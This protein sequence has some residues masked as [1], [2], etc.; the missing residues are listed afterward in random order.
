MTCSKTLDFS[1]R[2]VHPSCTRIKPNLVIKITYACF[3]PP[4][5]SELSL[6]IH[7]HSAYTNGCIK[8]GC[9]LRHVT[10][11]FLIQ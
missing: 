7:K 4:C 3:L 10:R 11:L 9:S 1:S 6:H 2:K 8:H 5:G